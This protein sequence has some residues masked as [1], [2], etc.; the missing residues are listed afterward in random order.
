MRKGSTISKMS[1]HSRKRKTKKKITRKRIVISKQRGGASTIELYVNKTDLSGEVNWIANTMEQKFPYY[2][3]DP[4][5]GLS[6]LIK[7][8]MKQ[9]YIKAF[10]DFVN[11]YAQMKYYLKCYQEI[12]DLENKIA[13]PH[14]Y[15]LNSEDMNIIKKASKIFSVIDI[16]EVGDW[17]RNTFLSSGEDA[18]SKSS[19]YRPPTSSHP[20][21][22]VR[23]MD[24]RYVIK[25]WFQRYNKDE[26]YNLKIKKMLII[27][28]K[29]KNKINIVV[30]WNTLN[31]PTKKD[32]KSQLIGLD[33]H[34][35][36]LDES[37]ESNFPNLMIVLN[38]MV[39]DKSL[40]NPIWKRTARV[41][42]ETVIDKIYSIR[43]SLFSMNIN[44]LKVLATTKAN[45]EHL[46]NV[47]VKE[48]SKIQLLDFIINPQYQVYFPDLSSPQ[49]PSPQ[50]QQAL[51]QPQQL[52]N[53]HHSLPM[54]IDKSIEE[55]AESL[56]AIAQGIRNSSSKMHYSTPGDNFIF[57]NFV[58]KYGAMQYFLNVYKPYSQA[59]KGKWE[60]SLKNI[61]KK[62]SFIDYNYG[63]REKSDID[64]L[65]REKVQPVKI[66][67]T[68]EVPTKEL[69]E[70]TLTCEKIIE[71]IIT[72]RLTSF[73]K[74]PKPPESPPPLQTRPTVGTSGSEN[75]PQPIDA[76]VNN[77]PPVPPSSESH[78]SEKT[79]DN[80]IILFNLVSSGIGKLLYFFILEPLA[81]LF[82]YNE[83][84]REKHRGKSGWSIM[85]EA[86]FTSLLRIGVIAIVL[87]AISFPTGWILGNFGVSFQLVGTTQALGLKSVT[88]ASK[89]GG[90]FWHWIINS[91]KPTAMAIGGSKLS[92]ILTTVKSMWSGGVGL[93][94][95]FYSIFGGWWW[96][97]TAGTLATLGSSLGSSMIFFILNK[98]CRIP[99]II[100]GLVLIIASPGLAMISH[101][102]DAPW[103]VRHA[104]KLLGSLLS[105]IPVIILAWLS[106]L[107]AGPQHGTEQNKRWSWTKKQFPDIAAFFVNFFKEYKQKLRGGGK[108]G[109]LFGELLDPIKIVMYKMFMRLCK[110]LNENITKSLNETIT[111]SGGGRTKRN[112]RTKRKKGGAS[113]WYKTGINDEDDLLERLTKLN[114]YSCNE[115]NYKGK[116]QEI[117]EEIT[118]NRYIKR[119]IKSQGETRGGSKTELKK[120]KRKIKRKTKRNRRINKNSKTRTK[121]KGGNTN[122]RINKNS[123]KRNKKGGYSKLGR[124]LLRF[125]GRQNKSIRKLISNFGNGCKNFNEELSNIIIEYEKLMRKGV[126]SNYKY[127]KL[128]EILSNK[129]ARLA[130]QLNG[131]TPQKFIEENS[132]QGAKTP[133]DNK[134][135][136]GGGLKTDDYQ[137]TEDIRRFAGELGIT[138]LRTSTISGASWLENGSNDQEW[139]NDTMTNFK[140]R[141]FY[142]DLYRKKD[143]EGIMYVSQCIMIGSL[144]SPDGDHTKLQLYENCESAIP[145]NVERTP[146]RHDWSNFSHKLNQIKEGNNGDIE[147]LRKKIS[148][149]IWMVKFFIVLRNKDSSEYVPFKD[150]FPED[151]LSFS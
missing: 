40:E 125:T 13:E 43:S 122:R 46:E 134:P 60:E 15:I 130:L 114:D 86:L 73:A 75:Q 111:S 106:K 34:V 17:I 132:F 113:E 68:Y 127:K 80:F 120:T 47:N 49:Q 72:E 67:K 123:K 95:K 99:D 146:S 137:E 117:N 101:T 3:P 21:K 82:G 149:V 148:S 76:A 39:F 89:W 97:G 7:R 4:S 91:A 126:I 63:T 90:S 151:M 16:N 108:I 44:D 105:G 107:G 94:S 26:M 50:P 128:F 116:V 131:D 70:L 59:F 52:T 62:F 140:L 145:S 84:E 23:D 143:R 6:V 36:Y 83:T 12:H 141:D 20:D 81:W 24:D 71:A 144:T 53:P 28:K 54:E 31:N 25:Q 109:E 79:V 14:K 10:K 78:Q 38:R 35:G 1:S 18:V 61:R 139:E 42:R 115:E 41:S 32:I 77:P 85:K 92:W 11:V 135:V 138:D 64:K 118:S 129:S 150:C 30:G 48:M 33:E 66:T 119:Y 5:P 9:R 22:E 147:D 96:H 58:K 100:W 93:W 65:L 69:Q 133:L 51:P 87:I 121:K 45:Q 27:I 142:D 55:K 112:K 57:I 74:S 102:D 19:S 29:I 37:P 104:F 103:G 88:L 124:S 110:V 98:V 136:R 2:D 56:L 8:V